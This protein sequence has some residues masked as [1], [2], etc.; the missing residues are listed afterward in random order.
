MATR[1]ITLVVVPGTGA[2][3]LTVDTNMTVADLVCQQ[4]LHGRDIIV[5]GAGVPTT[6]WNTTTLE[7]AV[8]VFATGSVK[9]NVERQVTLVVVPG[10]G[11]RSI[12]I[13]DSM[14]LA[15]LACRE[16]LH[17]RDLII[18]G[19]GVNPTQWN[20]TTLAG[21]V[22]IFA[23]GS[24]KGNISQNGVLVVVPG[25]GAKAVTF[26]S[27]T[28]VAQFVCEHNLH[29]RDII[30]D[31][32]GC[33]PSSWNQITLG[34]TREIFATGSVKGNVETT[35]VLVVVPGTGAK[36][37]SFDSSMTV[38]DLV[39]RENLHGRDIIINGNGIPASQW[40]TTTLQG[41][42][43]IFATGSVKGNSAESF[44]VS[45][46]DIDDAEKAYS[47]LVKRAVNEYGHNRS[48]GTIST[49]N[50]FTPAML[51]KKVFSETDAWEYAQERLK[52][53]EKYECEALELQDS[54]ANRGFLFYGWAAC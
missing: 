10:T 25:T 23:T 28:T 29:G 46:Y 9:G 35:G 39:C 30:L 38:A 27:E 18:N 53:M 16:N 6:T 14:T 32:V 45:I 4:N 51:G 54:K 36:S 42:V 13:D 2:R 21:A 3:S 7:N 43:E 44:I 17:G 49:V 52:S 41:A 5:N 12:T 15:D 34:S 20:T 22:E 47:T 26:D 1:N 48:N 11:A 24:V 37:I 31:G 50:G 40:N 33:S 19:N 8:E